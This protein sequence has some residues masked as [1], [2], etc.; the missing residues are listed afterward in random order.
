MKNNFLNQLILALALICTPYLSMSQLS[1]CDANV[2]Y[3]YVDLTGSPNGTWISPSHSRIGKCCGAT[4]SDNCTSFEIKID[5]KAV[6]V[7]FD[8]YSGAMPTGA[9]YYQV[10]CGPLVPIG[11]KICLTGIGPHRLTFCK[12]GNNENTYILSTFSKPIFPQDTTVR[13]GCSK[14]V[15]VLG[16]SASSVSWTSIYPGTSGQYNSYLSCTDCIS[17]S[18]SPLS[19]APAYVDYKI[20]GAPEANGCGLNLTY[21]D[22]V[23]LF[24]KSSL[25]GTVSPSPASY[26]QTSPSSGITLTASAAGG[27]GTY[28]YIW[29]NSSL[30]IVGNAKNYFASAQGN[31]TVEIRDELYNSSSCPS[32]ILNVPVISDQIHVVNAGP[33]QTVCTNDA[34]VNLN[35]SV[36]NSGGIWSGGAGTFSPGSGNL[37]PTYWP[38]NSELAAGSLKL[39]LTSNNSGACPIV[40]DDVIITF[41]APLQ[42]AMSTGTANCN[43]SLS[44]LN[45]SASGGKTPYIYSW[46]TGSSSTSISAP[47]GTYCVTVTDNLGCNSTV[48]KTVASPAQ[49]SITMSS[50]NL[51]VNGGSDGTATASLSGGSS[52]YTYLWSNNSTAP[53]ITGLTYGVYTVSVRDSKGCVINGSVVVNEP[54]CLGL[55]LSANHTNLACYGNSNA[56]ATAVA[57]GGTLPYSYLWNDNSN[58]NTAQAINLSGGTYTVF[59]TDA[60][61][62]IT[63]TSVTIAMPA[64]I[65]NTFTYSD[66]TNFTGNNGSATANPYGGTPAYTYSWGNGSGTQTISNLTPGIYHVNITDNN[67][68]VY[69]DSV[70]I[71]KD[72]CSNLRTS[73][74]TTAL[75]CFGAGNGTATAFVNIG[76]APFQYLWSNGGTSN[77]ISGLSSGTYSL[78]ITDA[79]GCYNL[80][81]F[82]VVQPAKL[83]LGLSPT[84]AICNGQNNGTIETTV[85]GGTYPYNFSWSNGSTAEDLIYLAPANY[86]VNIV[87][88]QGCGIS[89]SV[90]VKEPDS[91]RT[92][93]TV[94]NPDCNGGSNG[95]IDLTVS[96]GMVPYS[97]LWSN[98]AVTQDLAAIPSGSYIVKVTDANSCKLSTDINIIVG[99]PALV[100]VDSTVIQCNSPGSGNTTVSIFPSG[101]NGGPYQISYDNGST[102][103]LAGNYSAVLL[104]DST[105]K[106][107]VKDGNNCSSPVAYSLLINPTVNVD[108][109]TFSQCFPVGTSQISVNVIAS[110][111]DGGPY[112][113]SFDNGASFETSGTYTK[114]LPVGASYYILVKDQKGC[115]SLASSIKIPNPLSA[116]LTSAVYSGGYNTS[117]NGNSDASIIT[118]VSGGTQPFSFSWNGPGTYTSN[119]QSISGLNAGTYSVIVTDSNNCSDSK[120]ITLAQPDS[121]I[122]SA[123]VTSNYN[124]KSVSCSGSSDGNADVTIVGGT[125]PYSIL[126][127]NGGT[128]KVLTG[129]AAGNYIVNV[130]DINGCQTISSVTLTEPQPISAS[131]AT[132]D[133]HCNGFATG[134]IDLTIS[135]GV[136]PYQQTWSRGDTTEDVFNL[137][138]GVYTAVIT[139]KNQC[140]YSV[141]AAINEMS[142]VV[143]SVSSTNET[144][145]ENNNGTAKAIVSG[146]TIPYSFIWSNGMSNADI[147]GLEAGSYTITV[148]DNNQCYKTDTIIIMQP[149]SLIASLSSPVYPN[150]HNVS[151]FQG[152]DGAIQTDVKG[153]TPPYSYLWSN[154][155]VT[156]DLSQVKAG[157]YNVVITDTM[158]CSANASVNLSD[159]NDLA[160][161]SGFS[162]NGD[163]KNDLFLVH[164]L[165]S[166]TNN[167]IVVVNRWG[168]TVFKAEPYRNNWNGL[169]SSGE[170]IPDGT[171]FVVL[172]IN[173]GEI[174]LKGF[175]DIRR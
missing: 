32:T 13:I 130:T 26:C 58:Q 143:L 160:M 64:A 53:T 33:D 15:P 147:S 135:G 116:S 62:C 111:G 49:L 121:L 19:G 158:G 129:M 83:S 134:S 78:R 54:R 95:S 112:Q 25:T 136:N 46:N 175:V 98:G 105:Y 127:N 28:T 51:T 76:T 40:S 71:N 57:T 123:T 151:T 61:S 114:S 18:F 29:R 167:K 174:I 99:E 96:G 138:A 173:G 14:V 69:Q 103:Q 81:S 35:G 171:Y 169:N 150:G 60:T 102:F 70:L 48:C 2:P 115:I 120:S 4:G 47:P 124:G 85:S 75:S 101:G 154:G 65:I 41:P 45:A 89:G 163:G 108:S 152:S 90:L 119:Q 88:A 126:W 68:C 34:K 91:L 172:T 166:Y 97:F 109:L 16:I 23:R 3:Y 133:V 131:S 20:C 168:N 142:P 84:D 27:T 107:M 118:A 5:P 30:S 56:S 149:A 110:G 155:S 80:K 24:I 165:E 117:C 106:V 137:N 31:Y 73:V 122:S 139:D 93:Y 37:T 140:T 17:P 44:T 148:R 170:E 141:N 1:S 42:V 157:D 162:P 38:T 94:N 39:T 161:P 21:C 63:S 125:M 12:P 104:L 79:T 50:T 82:N 22:T 86:T 52:P 156:K 144:C 55:N 11:Q 92:S 74:A 145:F 9:L 132:T 164:G 146:G 8:V 77:S 159:P 153:G 7:S 100:A 59:V 6:Q 87:D 72:S 67:G 66:V 36:T 43:G 113:I 10:N 128:T